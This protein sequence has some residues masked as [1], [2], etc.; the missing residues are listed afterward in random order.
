MPVP[1]TLILALSLSAA[2]GPRPIATGPAPAANATPAASVPPAASAAVGVSSHSKR[3]VRAAARRADTPGES[4]EELLARLRRA[5]SETAGALEVSISQIFERLTALGQ[6]PLPGDRQEV[7][8]DLIA[9]GPEAC[10]LLVPHLDPGQSP[11]GETRLK[12]KILAEVLAALPTP[13]TTGPLLALARDGSPEGKVL[14]FEALGSTTE[15]ERVSPAV[16]K[17]HDSAR[18]KARDAALLALAMIGGPENEELL[19]SCLAHS[20]GTVIERALAALAGA[21]NSTLETRVLDLLRTHSVAANHVADLI[22]YY[23]AMP[24]LV[25]GDCALELVRLAADVDLATTRRVALLEA[26]PF[27]EPKLDSALKKALA[28]LSESAVGS[29]SEAALVCRTLL[30]DKRAERELM[31]TYDFQVDRNPGESNALLRRA[32]INTRIGEYGD[33]VK[34]YREALK[35]RDFF[36]RDE[37]EEAKVELARCYCKL[38]RLKDASKWLSDASISLNRLRQ[39]SGDSD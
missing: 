16:R 33:A 7:R 30:G 29:V 15:P 32:E 34:D 38:G 25:D 4:L 37:K 5:R 8:D 11:T 27:F 39:L 17:L 1:T 6:R 22:A 26:L 31:E 10:P 2:P 36:R 19:A 3:A 23:R 14:A 18:G 21:R 24:N 20:E 9:L 35:C 12:S 28:P 13:A